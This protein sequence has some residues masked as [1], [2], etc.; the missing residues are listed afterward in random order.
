MREQALKQ[1][2]QAA[3][4]EAVLQDCMHF[5]AVTKQRL[6]AELSVATE[7][8]HRSKR[9]R[10]QKEFIQAKVWRASEVERRRRSELDALR[11]EDG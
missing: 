2:E 5:E 7:V 1:R 4:A 8:G 9:L 10:E 3:D 11:A 6:D